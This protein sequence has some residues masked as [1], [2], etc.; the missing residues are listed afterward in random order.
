[1]KR[2]LPSLLLVVA[3][4]I[5][6]EFLSP[7]ESTLCILGLGMVEFV[8]T[9]IR[10]KSCDWLILL[11]T[12]LFCL[13]NAFHMLTQQTSLNVFQPVMAGLMFCILTGVLA[14]SRK[15]L[16][17]ALPSSYRKSLSMTEAQERG[18]KNTFKQLFYFLCIYTC[19]TF[20]TLLL[21][22]GEIASFVS[23]PLLY[24][25]LACFFVSGFVKNI[26]NMR[27][28]KKEEWLPV[29]NEKGEVRGKAPRSICHSGSKLLHP[30]VHLHILNEQK[31]IFLQKRSMKKDLLPGLWDTA[32]GGHIGMNENVEQALKRETR[33][34]LGITDFEAR[35][36]G[37]YVWETSRERELVFSFI[38]T[39]YNEIRID[40][41]EVEEGKFWSAQE[42][43]AGIK[44]NELTPNFIHEYRTILKN[45]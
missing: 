41:E 22:S 39:R 35:F 43:A 3:Y 32:V 17:A 23:G 9:R 34:E 36:L 12:L 20:I 16:Q 21:A 45:C 18:I 30:V 13:P 11:T 38:C 25:L 1:M 37:N 42:I 2:W 27:R 24:I 33:E 5:A 26:R 7:L 40:R 19:L 6:D 10:E 14:Y 28:Y 15:G 8:Y 29:V 4:F 44:K 31:E